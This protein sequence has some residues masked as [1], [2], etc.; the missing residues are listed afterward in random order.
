MVP[1][2]FEPLLPDSQLEINELPNL[3]EAEFRV[4]FLG[5]GDNII[6]G[7]N[8]KDARSKAVEGDRLYN[9]KPQYA[10][11][12]GF[13]KDA[14]I[15]FIN[16]ETLMCGVGYD[17][18]YYP[19]FNSPQE[20]GYDLVEIGFDVINIA[21]NHM[22][23]KG[24]DGLD[25]TIKFWKSM[26]VLMVGGY[27]NSEDFD[28]IRFIQRNGL[29]IAF[30]SYTYGTNGLRKSDSS[31]I[32]VPYINDEDIIRQISIAKEFAD[33][34]AVS[35]H[36][37]N[38]GAFKPNNEQKRVAQLIA[39]CGADA[40]IGHHPHV[41][42]PVEW[43]YGKE[44]NK[45]LC[46][47]SMGNFMAEQDYDYNMVGGMICFDIVCSADEDA[48]IENVV[49]IPT[50]F[51]FPAN[52]YTN[53]IYP[54]TEYTRELAAVHGVKNYYR[55]TLTYDGLIKY[56]TDI[57]SEEFLPGDFHEKLED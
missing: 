31:E 32:I 9:F 8:I 14:D 34:V 38:E 44:G 46:V 27:E 17:I 5:C 7:G 12:S 35:I 15:S 48:V 56:A 25:K 22:L 23:D 11:V 54:M 20:L 10:E 50:V 36:W 51:H 39:D 4:S 19:R 3:S 26:D 53:I 45:T 40:I 43:L 33:F 28:N 1:Q 49:F 13:I 55:H 47:Y 21:N 41:L 2:E 57:I 18:S 42:Q 30:L 37:G 6:Y 29:K 24:T 52:F 16:Q